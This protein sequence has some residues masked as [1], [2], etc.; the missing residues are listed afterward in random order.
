MKI[1]MDAC[2][3]NRPVDDQTQDKIR[4]ES[5]AILAI[6]SKCISG[7][8]QLLSSQIL[9]IELKNIPDDW[10]RN[11]VYD[12]Y[13]VATEK[14]A[15]NDNITS[16]SLVIQKYGIKLF[17][18]LHVAS[19]EYSRADIFLTTDKSLLNATRLLQ[20]KVIAANPLNWFM[21]VDDND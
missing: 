21:E 6:L 2:C 8:W 10:K 4:I 12:L 7:K 20:L 15:L 14:V 9:D 17:D 11:K 19:A 5:D 16:R 18:S 3:L 13:K 1:Y